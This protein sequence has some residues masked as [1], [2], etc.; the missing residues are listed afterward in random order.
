LIL[1]HPAE[2]FLETT[3]RLEDISPNEDVEPSAGA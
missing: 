2:P 1:I 3:D